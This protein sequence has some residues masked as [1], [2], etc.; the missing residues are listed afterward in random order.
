MTLGFTYRKDFGELGRGCSQEKPIY[1]PTH[2]PGPLL[3]PYLLSC[4]LP[5]LPEVEPCLGKGIFSPKILSG[6]V[7]DLANLTPHLSPAPNTVGKHFL[8]GLSY[9]GQLHTAL[10]LSH[11]LAQ[12]HSQTSL[13]S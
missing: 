2:C 10:D 7:L 13:C 8:L 4:V 1:P 6:A 12:G 3:S 9:L 11:I 5:V